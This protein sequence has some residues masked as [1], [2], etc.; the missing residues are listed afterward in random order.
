MV[1]RHQ[2]CK[3]CLL[4]EHDQVMDLSCDGHAAVAHMYSLPCSFL[5]YCYAILLG[6]GLIPGTEDDAL[7]FLALAKQL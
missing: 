3:T 6:H 1:G 7:S 2:D 4:H 5:R